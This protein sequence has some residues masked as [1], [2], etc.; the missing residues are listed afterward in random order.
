ML[1]GFRRFR[2]FVGARR[3]AIALAAQL[4]RRKEHT[5]HAITSSQR[6]VYRSATSTG[7]GDAPTPAARLRDW[8]SGL[9]RRVADAWRHDAARREFDR[10][11][12]GTLRDLGISPSEFDSYWAEAHGRV[13]ATRRRVLDH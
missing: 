6:S 10:L 2:H 3:R 7:S 11:D 5:M 12:A 8:L 13:E 1:G 9:S 4:N